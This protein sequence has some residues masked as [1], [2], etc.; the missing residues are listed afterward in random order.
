[1]RGEKCTSGAEGWPQEQAYAKTNAVVTF[2][3][4]HAA[5]T[6]TFYS[7]QQK[8]EKKNGSLGR[9]FDLGLEGKKSFGS[10]ELITFLQGCDT[11]VRK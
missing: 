5:S 11:P 10:E 1:M 8:R 9:L 3:A 6:K 2:R 7:P 4:V